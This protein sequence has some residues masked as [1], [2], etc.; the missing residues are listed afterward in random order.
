MQQKSL[1]LFQIPLTQI[2]DKTRSEYSFKYDFLKHRIELHDRAGVQMGHIRLPL[3]FSLDG[4]LNILNK[5][6]T[7]LY[8]SIES[9][10]AAL[11]LMHGKE[12]QYHTTFSSYMTR[13]KQGFSQIKYLKKKG[14]SRAGSRVRLAA[15]VEFFENINRR[16]RDLF[17]QHE[18]ARIAIDCSTTLIPFLYGSK[19]S[20]PFEKN[21]VRLYK[22]P[23]HI[24]NSNYNSLYAAIKKLMAPTLFYKEE[25]QSEFKVF[26]DLLESDN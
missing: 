5:E 9:G 17:N 15:T 22:I 19:E 12:M 16:T 18:I 1:N 11:I 13:K 6:N 3:F 25:F 23:V 10:N 21:D 26:F 20:P 14:K 24:N 8:L 2:L 7:I 4:N